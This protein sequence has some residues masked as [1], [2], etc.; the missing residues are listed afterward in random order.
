MRGLWGAWG[1]SGAPEDSRRVPSSVLG[2]G[3]KGSGEPLTGPGRTQ[4]ACREGSKGSGDV[5]RGSGE[6]QMDYA[7]IAAE[8]MHM[9]SICI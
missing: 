6:P 2:G 4:E 9:L 7:R 1:P 8:I 3:S 5:R